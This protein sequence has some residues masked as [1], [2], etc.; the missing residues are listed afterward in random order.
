MLNHL[1]KQRGTVLVA[2]LLVL[3]GISLILVA[4]SLTTVMEKTSTVRHKTSS[5]ALYAADSGVEAAKQ[6]MTTY[7]QG[8]LDSLNAVWAGNGAI[9]P[10][11]E[12]FFPAN[13]FTLSNTGDPSYSVT[14]TLAFVDSSLQYN[15]QAYDYRFDVVSTGD[16][17]NSQRG[18]ST[19]GILRVSATR[20]SF[21]DYLIFTDTHLVPGGYDI[22][23][24]TSGY[25]DGRVHT[26]DEYKFAYY[27]TFLDNVTSVN[28]KAV[29]YNGG[30][31]VELNADFNGTNDVPNFYGGFNRG[32]PRIDLPANAF[33]QER[34]ALGGNPADMSPVTDSERRTM[35]GLGGSGSV[36]TGVYVPNSGGLVTGGI[37][38]SGTAKDVNLSVDNQDH[39]IYSIRDS[40][41]DITNVELD[42]DNNATV[43][44]AP[45]GS[46]TS[47]SGISR[48]VL[49]SGGNINSLSGPPRS[50]NTVV[51]AIASKAQ[52]TVVAAGDVVIQGDLASKNFDG[53]ESILGVFTSA[54]D[55][56]IGNNAPDELVV[57]GFVMASGTQKVFTVD[58]YYSGSYRGQVHLRG[59]MITNYYGAFGTFSW[60]GSMTGY[61]R[62]FRY[63]RRGLIPPY[64]PLTQRYST[65]EPDPMVLAWREN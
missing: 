64:F 23:F 61:G 60:D 47:Y 54:G 29:Y 62:D 25:F 43:V 63:D 13:G 53:G 3:T 40:N 38:I 2:A 33:S 24:H 31:P 45:D 7:A 56:R 18:V 28:G 19:E 10:N 1:R 50:G 57:D 52:M 16:Y 27:P 17:N 35:L 8:V 39:Q 59:G 12:G 5:R 22:W 9:I 32:V 30:S 37:Y 46:V 11:P 34:A 44:T 51:P 58:N 21:A 6:V 36:P 4:V 55:I 20:G 42:F 26:N 65:D 14:A 41:N 48:G 49:Y 15:S